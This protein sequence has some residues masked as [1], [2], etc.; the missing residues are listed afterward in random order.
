MGYKRFKQEKSAPFPVPSVVNS[1]SISSSSLAPDKTRRFIYEKNHNIN[2]EFGKSIA[3]DF[4]AA[5]I[6]FVQ[7]LRRTM[8]RRFFNR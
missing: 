4:P 2:S 1:I 3:A 8:R 7:T 6:A 5:P